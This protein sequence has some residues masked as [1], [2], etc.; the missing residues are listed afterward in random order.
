LRKIRANDVRPRQVTK[1]GLSE[2]VV[3]HEAARSAF[4]AADPAPNPCGGLSNRRKQSR[5]RPTQTDRAC[6]MFVDARPGGFSI[7]G[8][9]K[10]V[11]N[12]EF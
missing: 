4:G 3:S 2:P 10:T 1:I 5:L 11:A 7:S 8:G 12:K 9:Q 6:M